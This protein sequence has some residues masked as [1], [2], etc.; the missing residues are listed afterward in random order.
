MSVSVLSVV[1]IF[2]SLMM[3]SICGRLDCIPKKGMLKTEP[4]VSVN[5]NLFGSGVFADVITLR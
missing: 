2:N 3:V 4:P 5:V 1:L